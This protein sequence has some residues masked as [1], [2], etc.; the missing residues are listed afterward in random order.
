MSSWPVTA[1]PK[2][3]KRK[4]KEAFMQQEI[5]ETYFPTPPY[6]LPK[7]KSQVNVI[8]QEEIIEQFLLTSRQYLELD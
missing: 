8:P 5:I 3:A 1:K 2:Q 4:D 6:Q 7:L